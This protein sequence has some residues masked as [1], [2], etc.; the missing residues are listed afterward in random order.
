MQP[1]MEAYLDI[2]TTGLSPWNSEITV[3][4]I[5]ICNG[6]ATKFAQLVGED[7]TADRILESLQGAEAIYTYNG[8][9]FNLP[10]IPVMTRILLNHVVVYLCLYSGTALSFLIHPYRFRHIYLPQSFL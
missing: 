4:G 5:Y 9:R 8:N 2:E 7:V 10:F 6:A 1:Y 3:V